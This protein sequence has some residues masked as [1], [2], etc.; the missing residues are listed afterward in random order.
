MD[1]AIN[2]AQAARRVNVTN[3]VIVAMDRKFGATF[4]KFAQPPGLLLPRVAKGDVAIS[5][6]N[7]IG[8]RQRFG[9]RVLEA[10]FNVLF[11]DLDA[12]LLKSPQPL[13]RDGDFIGE[14][15]WGRPPSL[16]TKWG[17]AI[18]TGFYFVRSRP[19]TI[20]IFRSTHF[21]ITEKRKRQPRWQASDQWAINHALDDQVVEW[22]GGKQKMKPITDYQTK[23]KDNSSRVGFTKLIRTKFVVLPHVHVARVCPILKHGTLKPPADAKKE[24]KKWALWQHLLRT[25]YV[26]HCFPPD[27]MPCPDNVKHGEKGCDKSII[28]GHASHIHGE[29][30]FDQRQGLWFMSD[31]W[32]ASIKQPATSD[33]F[34]WLRLHYNGKIPGK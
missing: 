26:L 31:G 4:S 11:V 33:F 1:L 20:T 3:F 19:E 6:L 18:C 9:L 23:Y 29:V 12:L 10:G 2:W 30:V 27:A 32:E 25:A 28:M 8:E 16:V 17:A 14:R 5:K 21:R 34:E 22:T 13:L 7:V 15:I 24:V